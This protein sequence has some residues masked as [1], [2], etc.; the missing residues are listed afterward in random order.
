[1][2]RVTAY[3]STD[4]RLFTDRATYKAHQAWLSLVQRLEL[5]GVG[6][7]TYQV[8]DVAAAMTADDDERADL[9][10]ELRIAKRAP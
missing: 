10:A 4:G 7:A 5:C 9:I 2:P 3:Q 8:E 1:M 6:S